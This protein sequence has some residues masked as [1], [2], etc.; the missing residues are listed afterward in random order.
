MVEIQK[1]ILPE[2]FEAVSSGAKHYEL[3]LNDFE[4]SPGDMLTLREWDQDKREYTG[5]EIRKAVTYVGKLK[6]DE[7]FWPKEEVEKKGLQI[8]SFQ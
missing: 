4:I 6:I 5:R 3:R 8:I 2:Y 7:F 1:K